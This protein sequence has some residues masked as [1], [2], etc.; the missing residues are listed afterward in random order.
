MSETVSKGIF[1]L[2]EGLPPTIFES[3]V[4]AHVR[5]VES[6]GV[7]MEVWAFAVTKSAYTSAV[8]ILPRLLKDHG[9]QIRL[10]RGVKPALPFSRQIN[11]LLLFRWLRHY[12]RNPDFIHGRTEYSTAVAAIIRSFIQFTLI[13]DAR[14]DTIS[15][16]ENKTSQM[17]A[18]FRW[19]A[20]LKRNAIKKWLNVAAKRC[21]RAIFVSQALR[22]LQAPHLDLLKTAIIPCLADEQLFYFDQTLRT[23]VR[24]RL[25]YKEEDIVIIYSG[26][27]AP[28]QCVPQTVKLMQHAIEANSRCHALIVTS[29]PQ[30]FQALIPPALQKRFTVT[31]GVLK[32]MNGFLNA[33]DVGVMLRE[34]NRINWVAS[35]VKFAEYS[36]A[37]LPVVT[38]DAVSQVS[39]FGRQLDSLILPSRTIDIASQV[40]RETRQSRANCARKILGRNSYINVIMGCYR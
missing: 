3:Q 33:A 40:V 9:V 6:A 38:T 20:P 19:L 14:G 5:A 37:G 12:K 36:L 10:F 22:E 25:G 15:E 31:S 18:P 35:P 7:Q 34:R 21:D 2:F 24:S 16:F 29:H 32:E 27:V 26:S 11:A 23:K 8:T 13:W 1:L 17:Q 39:E 28:W 30:V 4:L